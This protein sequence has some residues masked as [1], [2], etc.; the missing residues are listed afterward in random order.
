VSVRVL[1]GRYRLGEQIGSGGMAKVY[2][3]E[4]SRLDRPVAVK[5][6]SAQ[7][8]SDPSFVDRF[9]REAQT[10][11][12]LSHPNIVGV[13][14]NGSEDDTHY[15]V[16]EFV[17]GRTLDEFL[18]GGGRLSP[19]KA[20]EVVEAICDALQYAHERG[21]VHRD[22]KPGNVMVTREGQVKVMDFGIARV[23]TTVETIA[24]TAAVLGTAAYL[25]P[26]QAKGERVDRRS[27]LYSLGC[28][29]YELLTGAPP[30][31]GDSA[32]AVAM[33]HVQQSPRVPSEK[34]RDI[35]P[36]MDAVVMKALAKNPDNRY[37]TAGELRED[38]ERLRRG[39]AVSATP[40]LA[41]SNPT[42]V[43]H[44]QPAAGEPTATLPPGEEE[45]GRRWWV[46]ALVVLAILALLG[47]LAWALASSLLDTGGRV[48]M[49]NLTGLTLQEA[50]ARLRQEGIESV[51]NVRPG[52]EAGAEPNTVID[53][54]PPAFD[55]V[56][57]DVEVTLT[58]EEQQRALTVP[59]VQGLDEDA[60]EAELE[61][62]P[63]NYDV[64]IQRRVNPLVERGFA[65]GTEPEAGAELAPDSPIVLLVSRG[66]GASPTP[67]V[68]P[69]PT[70]TTVTVPDVVCRSVASAQNRITAAGLTW[71]VVGSQ[72]NEDCPNT[73]KVAAQAPAGGTEV[74]E[75]TTVK[76]WTSEPE[77]TSSPSA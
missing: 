46:V 41:A 64:S 15:I 47:G 25:S 26:E 70:P 51:P 40:I 68:S 69:T 16:M 13:Y 66:E 50:N 22:V 44:R 57:P 38:L 76:L 49:P 74:A 5:I 35:T 54:D 58:V 39:E 4:D 56:S 11:A 12:K 20:V 75:E 62:D 36:Q 2:R 7:F 43:V 34:N 59:D 10:A 27:D 30:F 73:N 42:Q 60:A 37:Q 45:G 24:Q 48:T 28:V 72:P 14:D 55:R 71:S 32:M 33:K 61:A 6:L 8:S 31:A 23:T 52:H 53:Q 1:G 77:S 65:I 29:L 3:A 18:A 9:R 63:Y 21:V 19:T 67:T 17:E